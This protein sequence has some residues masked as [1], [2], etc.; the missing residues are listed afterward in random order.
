MTFF[1]KQLCYLSP[2]FICGILALGDYKFV[3]SMKLDSIVWLLWQLRVS[4]D[5]LRGKL[6]KTAFTAKYLNKSF[7]EMYLVF[8]QLF[9]FW[10]T[11][12]FIS[13]L[14]NQNAKKM[15]KILI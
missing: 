3:F 10:P 4:I 7:I 5:L 2:N 1:L 14:G 12:I 15:K 8:Y 13:F 11:T 6:K 9:R